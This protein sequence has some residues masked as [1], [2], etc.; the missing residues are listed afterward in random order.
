MVSGRA[1]EV[2]LLAIA[3]AACWCCDTEPVE[4]TPLKKCNG[5]LRAY[6]CSR[7]C[8]VRDWKGGH[9]GQCQALQQVNRVCAE[10]PE[11]AK[12]CQG[13]PWEGYVEMQVWSLLSRFWVLLFALQK[14]V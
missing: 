11:E 13:M 9:K 10:P 3:G 2:P 4:Q 14:L 6:Y 1:T 5:C 7:E 8:Q 12:P